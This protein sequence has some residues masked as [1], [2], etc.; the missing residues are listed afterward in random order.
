MSIMQIAVVEDDAREVATV[1]AYLER[2]CSENGLAMNLRVFQDGEDL[3]EDYRAEFDIILMDIQMQF[4]DG[5]TAAKA[6]RE[7]DDRVILIFLTSM[8]GYAIQGYEVGATDYILKPAS[9]EVFSKK[10]LRAVKMLHP[11]GQYA[12]VLPVKG[13]MVRMDVSNIYYIESRSHQ[14]VYQTKD[15]EISVRG[16]LDDLEGELVPYGFF[17]SN[18]GLL[19]NLHYVKAVRNECCE[20]NGQLLPISRNRKAE[21][22]EELTKML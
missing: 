5:M 9:Y 4:M 17:R 22:M 3:M 11:R 18:R 14:M 2:F 1:R 15:G 8:A 12:V 13:G 20:I 16:R 7:R 10:L 6:V 19:V 21:F